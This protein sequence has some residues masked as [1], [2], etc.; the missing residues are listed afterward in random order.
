MKAY[1]W[2]ALTSCVWLGAL[3]V[4]SEEKG[5]PLGPAPAT[6]LLF[7][8]GKSTFQPVKEFPKVRGLVGDIRAYGRG[9]WHMN[10][11]WKLTDTGGKGDKWCLKVGHKQDEKSTAWVLLPPFDQYDEFIFPEYDLALDVK[12]EKARGKLTVRIETEKP[13]R[14]T[15]SF[16]LVLNGDR[17]WT[18]ISFKTN[19]PRRM[20][21]F[22]LILS[23][24]GTGTVLVDNVYL[25][26]VYNGPTDADPL[27]SKKKILALKGWRLKLDPDKVGRDRKWFHLDY[28]DKDW[29]PV[30]VTK[31]WENQGK[32]GD[33]DG[34]GWYR[35]NVKI[36]AKLKGRK[37]YLHFGGADEIAI[38][39]VNGVLVGRH[40]GWDLPFSLDITKAARYG[41]DNLVAVMVTDTA[42]QGGLY[43][44]VDL[45]TNEKK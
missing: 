15:E 33:Y 4:L 34:V 21:R 26:P 31:G 30:V 7:D 19:T 36:P 13:S 11:A 8:H 41:A 18:R 29:Q 6:L 28:D 37:V 10:G 2:L 14:K 35:A 12:A 22:R 45:M 17:H 44:P 1:R 42:F 32:V 24:E 43:K 16:P 40:S 27:V 5:A 9:N 23:Y 25:W 38:V 3:S 39:W 20:W